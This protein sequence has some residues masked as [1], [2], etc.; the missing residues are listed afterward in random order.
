MVFRCQ[1]NFFLLPLLLL[2]PPCY[3]LLLPDY[4]LPTIAVAAATAAFLEVLDDDRRFG[5]ILENPGRPSLEP[6]QP[7][8]ADHMREKL[9]FVI[10]FIFFN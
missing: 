6:E 8:A 4:P 7:R 10:I 9:V 1:T 5:V 3:V 2:R